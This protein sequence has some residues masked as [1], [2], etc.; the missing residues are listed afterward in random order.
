MLTIFIQ[1]KPLIITTELTDE[2]HQIG[3]EKKLGILRHPEDDPLKSIK[4]SVADGA[5]GW[6]VVTDDVPGWLQSFRK[7]F[8]PIEAAG[9]LVTNPEG[10]LLL[11][12]RRGKW[13]L[14]KGKMEHGETPEEAALREVTEET[15]LE[16]ISI[17]KKLADSWHTYRQDGADVLKETHW[18]KMDFVGHELT[19][20]QIEEDILDIQ[21]IKPENISKYIPFSYPNLEAVFLA[22][23]CRL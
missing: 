19:V 9:G 3:E 14:P 12:F 7:Q 1:G 5:S 11:I 17:E 2:V 21:W 22:A 15:G 13:D 4:D 18:F 6:I 10:D 8:R 23:G 20:P 16:H